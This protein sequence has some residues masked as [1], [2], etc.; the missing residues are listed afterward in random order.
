MNTLRRVEPRAAQV[1]D[2]TAAVWAGVIAGSA[3]LLFLTFVA[4]RLS[5]LDAWVYLRLIASVPLGSE[6]LAPPATFDIQV[7][8]AAIV[9][10]LLLS[11]SFALVS[12][13][14][15]HRWGMIV[16]ILGGALFGAA[17]YVINFWTLSLFFPWFFA[18]RGFDVLLG[19]VV[20]GALAGGIYE[21]LEVEEF[22]VASEGGR[23]E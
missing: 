16:G 7:L 2:L 12:A 6:V 19:H 13:F 20:F 10:Q 5:G 22:E 18:M 3:F 15:L 23:H 11:V 17:L 14:V 21:A 9:T 8:L 1:M 4:P